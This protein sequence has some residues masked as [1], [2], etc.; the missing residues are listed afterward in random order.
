MRECGINSLK[1]SPSFC[2]W[3]CYVVQQ[4]SINFLKKPDT[5]Y[6]RLA[7]H[8]LCHPYSPWGGTGVCRQFIRPDETLFTKA[9][10]GWELA[11]RP[12]LVQC[13]LRVW[14]PGANGKWLGNVPQQGKDGH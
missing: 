1:H 5:D 13:E 9:G 4:G 14:W 3:V 8:T 11:H 7:G 12:V 2:Y 6:F 10:A